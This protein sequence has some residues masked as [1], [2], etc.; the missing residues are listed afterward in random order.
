LFG[1]I[2]RE[3]ETKKHYNACHASVQH[4]SGEAVAKPIGMMR[5]RFDREHYGNQP[6]Y[7]PAFY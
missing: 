6:T 3:D 5:K 2:K 4:G 7:L 1:S